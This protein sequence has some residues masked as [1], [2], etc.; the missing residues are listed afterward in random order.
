[1]VW[2][3]SMWLISLVLSL[4]SALIATL[5][6]QWARRYVEMPHRPSEPN[7]R[8]RVRSFVFH[9][10]VFYRMRFAVQIA[11]TLLHFSVY[12]FFAGLV[13]A[14]RTIDKSVAIAVDAAVGV[15]AVAYIVLSLLPCFDVACPYR[16]P[17]SYILWYPLHLILSTAALFL[18]WFVGLLHGC[19]VK[20][21]LDPVMT[22]RQRILVRWLE[23]RDKSIKT[24]WRYIKDGLGK[25]I[26]TRGK[27]A[28]DGDRRIVTRLFS[29]LTPG[30]KGKLRKF[31]AS[32]SRDRVFE[33]IPLIESGT[34]VLRESLLTLLR[35]SASTSVAESDEEASVRKRS[36]VVCLDAIHFIAKT[37]NVPDLNI[38]RASFANIGLMR[39]L[40][41]DVDDAIRFSSRSICALLAKQVV[42]GTLEEPQLRWLH[43][44]T[45]EAPRAIYDANMATRDRMNLKS[46]VYGVFSHQVGD[47]PAESFKETLAILLDVKTDSDADSEA[48]FRSRFTEE[49]GW[50]QQ[51][52]RQDSRRIVDRLRSMFPF[53]PP[54]S[55][56]APPTPN[57]MPTPTFSYPPARPLAFTASFRS[58]PGHITSPG[59]YKGI[60]IEGPR[61][62][63]AVSLSN[64]RA[65]SPSPQLTHSL[66]SNVP[67][68]GNVQS[69]STPPPLSLPAPYHYGVLVDPHS[70]LDITPPDVVIPLP[71]PQLP[72]FRHSHASNVPPGL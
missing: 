50:I 5:L 64:P 38:L 48:N 56:D 66:T 14:F 15:F 44:V 24:H 62:H 69:L 18:R 7:H 6:Q 3:N 57:T 34:I 72:D 67:H 27:N 71:D 19:L 58:L 55:G 1:M 4:T 13:V 21:S 70:H 28:E 33:L 45:R 43:D 60:P 12:L 68:G 32:I 46:F 36:L 16:T 54:D 61:Y 29:L 8:A 47:P 41:E 39:T 51:Q 52:D 2:V 9:G 65:P 23:S 25:S 49:V 11:P 22:G 37:P 17:M 26:I 20:S 63:S 10:T 59:P 31:A 40:W 30:D 42:R 35:T 53:L